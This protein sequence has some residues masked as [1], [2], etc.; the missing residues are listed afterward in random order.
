M[1]K[2]MNR[3][4]F[5][6][7]MALTFGATALAAC[8]PAKTEPAA[9][10]A[11]EV[12]VD[13][14][15]V[16][17]ALPRKETLYYNGYQ[18]GALVGWNP[19]SSNNNNWTIAN[20]ANARVVVF[21]TPFVYN[22]LDGKQ[23][24]LLA[25]GDYKWNDARTEIT[26]KI[27]KAA[28]WSDGSPVTAE[29]AAYTWATHLKYETTVGVGNKDYIDTV[30]AVDASTVTVKGK[31]DQDGKA[32]NPL[33]VAAFVSDN[34][35][36][37]AA[38][39]KKLEARVASDATKLKADT[40][41]DV[42]ASGPYMKFY[43]D[44]QKTVLIRDEKYWGADASMW[45]KL[46]PPRYMA[47]NI[48]KDNTA[49][50][51]AFKAGE[52][53]VSQ[54]FIANVQ[55]L[56]LDDKLPISTYMDKAPY[57]ICASLP[58]AYFNKNSYGLDQIA[59]RKAIAIATDYDTIIANAMTNQSPTFKDVPRSVMNPTAGE[60]AL[61]DHD[62]VK[63][64]QWIGNDIEGAKKLL[65]D[66]G[67]KEGADGFRTYN[68]KKLSYKACCPNGWAD[69]QAAME[70]IAAAGKKI[71]IEITTFYPEWGT[72]Q[73]VFVNG[74]QTEYDIFMVWSNGAGPTNPW[75]RVRQL[76]GGE[77]ADT[78]NNW[79]GN[80]GGYKNP[81]IDEIIKAIPAETDTAKLKV[82][83]TEATK[84]YLTDIPSFTLM[85]RPDLFD[86]ENETVW[87]NYPTADDGK[88][89]PPMNL[90]NGYAIAGLYNITL[91]G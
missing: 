54:Q 24:P 73:T 17:K 82:L 1:K 20:G 77:F 42:V 69:W 25:D 2:P 31:L 3:R 19:Y 23:Y 88:N 79:N 80:W 43:V 29:D 12:P 9:P 49:G 30:V 6:K 41:E 4:L 50:D 28:K 71:G 78:K 39:T 27:K 16:A 10:V 81:R 32:A 7:G 56:W 76:M 91:V 8:A 60:Q 64:L 45:G 66:A 51:I 40:G 35:I 68:G 83:Y 37:Q 67:I 55:K 89:I 86:A 18:W 57:G 14:A 38:W 74:D 48:F 5:L 36:L 70:I 34:Y 33:V 53:D 26:Y 84:I 11:T 58:T 47:H 61:F 59:I 90:C 44:D 63:D 72:Y 46:P 75:G 65:D 62:A 52:V 85:Y 15:T 87:T 21:E 13:A 22:M